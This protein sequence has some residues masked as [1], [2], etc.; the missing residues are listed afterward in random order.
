MYDSGDT[1]LELQRVPSRAPVSPRFLRHRAAGGGG[2]FRSSE[3]AHGSVHWR[4]LLR[5]GCIGSLATA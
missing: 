2:V 1:F 4:I 3:Q 5:L